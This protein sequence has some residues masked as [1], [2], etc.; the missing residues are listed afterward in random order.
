MNCQYAGL[1]N[2]QGTIQE[3]KESQKQRA[4][5]N[6]LLFFLLRS[7]RCRKILLIFLKQ[8]FLSRNKIM[9]KEK[10]LSISDPMQNLKKYPAFLTYNS[11]MRFIFLITFLFFVSYSFS[12][13][14]KLV[15]DTTKKTSVH[16]P[17]KAVILSAI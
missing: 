2:M 6:H 15:S 11:V 8:R 7:K 17:K 1:K 5:K 3:R 14:A 13:A 4:K 16:S 12:Q 9:A 10:S